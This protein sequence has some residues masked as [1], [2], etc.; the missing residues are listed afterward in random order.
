[1]QLCV[2]MIDVEKELISRIMRL[3]PPTGPQ[4]QRIFEFYSLSSKLMNSPGFRIWNGPAQDWKA[5]QYD[6]CKGVGKYAGHFGESLAKV[7]QVETRILKL[8]TPSLF[9]NRVIGFPREDSVA[10]FLDTL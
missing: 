10:A 6:I 5:I 1:Q 9:E 8:Y 2:H 3:Y 7:L 4:P